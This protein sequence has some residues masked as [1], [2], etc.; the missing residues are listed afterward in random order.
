VNSGSYSKSSYRN[1]IFQSV[2]FCSQ[3]ISGKIGSSAYH[4]Q[5]YRWNSILWFLIARQPA[6]LPCKFSARFLGSLEVK[7]SGFGLGGLRTRVCGWMPVSDCPQT[8]CLGYLTLLESGPRS[9]TRL[10]CSNS[11]RS[12]KLRP[13]AGL[14]P[15]WGF[16]PRFWAG[17]AVGCSSKNSCFL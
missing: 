1:S 14:C 12:G 8:F 4:H 13:P 10:C 11:G 15:F 5:Y 16:E 6:R 3:E 7:A 17:F 2:W 9:E